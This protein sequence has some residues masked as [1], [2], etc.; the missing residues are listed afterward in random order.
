VERVFLGIGANTGAPLRAFEQAAGMLEKILADQRQA[1]VFLSDPL[2]VTDQPVYVNTVISGLTDLVP[3]ELLDEV[4]RIETALGRNRP[5]ERLKGERTLDIDILLYGN[6]VLSETR[7]VIPHPG[8]LERKFVLLPL[9]ELEP[10]L[11]DPRSGLRFAVALRSMKS[12]GIYY[13]DLSLYNF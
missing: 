12:Q 5:H 6:R 1:R 2:Y 13:H 7:L 8:M 10:E 4:Q 9:L 3:F 11:I